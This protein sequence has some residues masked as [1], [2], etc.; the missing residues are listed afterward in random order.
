MTL[1]LARTSVHHDSITHCIYPAD[2]HPVFAVKKWTRVQPANVSSFDLPRCHHEPPR[3]FQNFHFIPPSRRPLIL[4]TALVCYRFGDTHRISA[5][6]APGDKGMQDATRLPLANLP[7]D[8]PACTML[9]SRRIVASLKN[10]QSSWFFG[11]WFVTLPS[12]EMHTHQHTH[13]ARIYWQRISSAAKKGSIVF[14]HSP[15]WFLDSDCAVG[16]RGNE[17]IIKTS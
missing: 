10:L 5:L 13:K 9:R 12:R 7:P 2:C 11:A 14:S 15:Q 4:S 17:P 1:Q 3:G 6:Q 8:L 16:W